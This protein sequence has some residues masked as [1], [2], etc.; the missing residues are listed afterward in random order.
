LAAGIDLPLAEVTSKRQGE[1]IDAGSGD[2]DSAAT[3]LVARRT[4]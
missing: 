3:Y 1:A 2:D 4:P